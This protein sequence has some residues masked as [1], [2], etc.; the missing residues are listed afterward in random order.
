MEKERIMEFRKRLQEIL[1]KARYEHTISVSYTCAALAMRYGYD[2]GK[3][4]LAG[5]LHD[6]AKGYSNEEL[7]SLCA[8]H[9]VLLRKEEITAPSVIHATYGAWVAEHEYGISDPEILS[10]IRYHTTGK[11]DMSILE[12]IVYIADY[13]EPRRDKAANLNEIRF[14]AFQDLDQTMERILSGTL[15]YLSQKGATIDPLTRKAYE[16]YSNKTVS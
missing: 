2:I 6:C 12:K 14:L 1:P 13:I 7:L 10:A 4:E 9:G 15:T 16:F 3:A 11:P 5:L 8:Q